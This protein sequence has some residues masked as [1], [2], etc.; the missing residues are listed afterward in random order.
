MSV[1]EQPTETGRFQV[2]DGWRGV[3]ILFVLAAHLLPLGPKAWQLNS[4]VGPLG[5][6]LFFTLSGFLITT[7][8]VHHSS[9]VDFL[10][11][12]FFRIVPLAWVGSIVALGV[13]HSSARACLAH[14]FFYANLP[15]IQLTEIGSHLWSLDVEVQF[16]VGIAVLV[17][18]LGGR[19]L[20][21]LPVLCILVTFG[22][23]ATGT[24]LSLI[25]YFRVDEI[26]AG[27][28]LALI[29]E[30]KLGDAPRRFLSW[31]N[32]YV[33]VVFLPVACHPST[34]FANYLRPYVA[35]ML[36]GTTLF[37]GRSNLARGLRSH[38]FDYVAAI[39]YAVYVNHQFLEFTW[40]GS[41]D[42]IVK[43]A[44]RPLLIAASVGLAH[45]STFYFEHPFIALGKRLSS[46]RRL[47]DYR[48]APV[49]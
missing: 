49:P 31:V 36:V 18:A 43:Y 13:S 41:G 2:L 19:G 39:S 45:L 10:I 20:M 42:K 26:L 44:K 24:E 34:G 1:P 28:V 17:G 38:A 37:N 48:R 27:G 14:F 5:M 40:L 9:V 32:P 23:I 16:Y 12:R 8:L 22:R 30:G 47:P 25:T 35:S 4:T 46:R 6:A 15:P 11:R 21:L 29:H 3:S 33:L 7:F